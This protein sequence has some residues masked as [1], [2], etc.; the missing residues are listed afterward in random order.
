MLPYI[1]QH[2]LYDHC[3]SFSEANTGFGT[4]ALNTPHA[5]AIPVYLCPS[6]ANLFGPR[7]YGRG[8]IDGIG[9]PTWWGMSNYAANFF[10]F[11]NPKQG[12]LQ[13]TTEFSQLSD[14]L[15]NTV[16]FA[17]RYGNCTNSGPT[18]PVYTSLWCDASTYWRS[19]FCINNLQRKPTAPGY[20]PCAKF[21]VTPDWATACDAS[22]A[23]SWH[24]GGMIVCLADG[25][26]RFVD[27]SI[28][29]N[30]W[31]MVCDP[32]DAAVVGDW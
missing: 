32:R 10:I 2:A 5:T 6:E 27:G 3:A 9:G 26:V 30:V 22:R 18:F 1:E 13:G 23:Q 17:E 4:H 16:M 28:A 31:A 20:P 7:G 8:K 12:N 25:S 19:V 11:G 21:Q 24:S 29:D 15:S 14:G